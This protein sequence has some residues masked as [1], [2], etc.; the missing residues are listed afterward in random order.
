MLIEEG[1]YGLWEGLIMYK[2]GSFIVGGAYS[3]LGFF[4]VFFFLFSFFFLLSLSPLLSTSIFPNRSMRNEKAS[5]Y[6]PTPMTSSSSSNTS[7]QATGS[8]SRSGRHGGPVSRGQ[9][10][11]IP[12]VQVEKDSRAAARGASLTTNGGMPSDFQVGL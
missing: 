12:I 9:P 4:S 3:L 7:D 1:I 6:T 5:R 8:S 11:G 10:T 2:Q